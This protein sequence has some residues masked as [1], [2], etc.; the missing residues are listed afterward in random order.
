MQVVTS[1]GDLPRQYRRDPQRRAQ[2]LFGDDRVYVERYLPTARH[3]E[4]QVLC[5]SYG[6]GVHLGQRDCSVQRRRQKI[7]EET[8]APG[9]PPEAGASR[10]ARRRVRG[11]ARGRA[12]SA[13]APSSSSS[14]TSSRFYFME[15]N[16]RIQ[17]EHP[18]TELTHGIDLVREQLRI[19]AG[20]P[21]DVSPGGPGAAR[22]GD[23]VPDQ[24]RGPGARLRAHARAAEPSSS[25]PP[26]RSSGS[27]PHAHRGRP[28]AAGYDSLLAKVVVWAPDRDTALL[29]MDRALGEL[30]LSGE[31]LVTTAGF[32][33]TVLADPDFV[34]GTDDTALLDRMRIAADPPPVLL[35]ERG[36]E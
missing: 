36:V 1:P 8:P 23:R 11:A 6:N 30:R 29:R 35:G 20:E 18:V 27:T 10:W 34:A 5:D 26:A 19:A 22:R 32:L 4:V 24:R 17:V 12:T 31:R 25:C 14:T 33:R 9:L 2:S 15:V 7:I 3:V 16:C 13:P 28:G 21:L